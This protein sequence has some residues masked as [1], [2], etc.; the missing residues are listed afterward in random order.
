MSKIDSRATFGRTRTGGRAEKLE[1]ITPTS[2]LP[3]FLLPS[4][5][6]HPT[7]NINIR[8]MTTFAAKSFDAARYFAFRPTYTQHFFDLTYAYH[9]SRGG[10]FEYALDLG[11]GPLVSLPSPPLI[12]TPSGRPTTLET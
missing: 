4:L 1:L 5:D 7:S 12:S 2:P 9:T 10:Q 8:A 3:L 11:C 6:H